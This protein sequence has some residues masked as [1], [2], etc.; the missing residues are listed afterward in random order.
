MYGR[1]KQPVSSMS[2]RFQLSVCRL[3][4]T[5][6]WYRLALGLISWT[7]QHVA[8]RWQR[9]AFW[10]LLCLA[11][12]DHRLYVVV[13]ATVIDPRYPGWMC[14]VWMYA[15][16]SGCWRN[17]PPLQQTQLERIARPRSRRDHQ[18]NVSATE[19]VDDAQPDSSSVLDAC[20][21]QFLTSA[22]KR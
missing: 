4:F 22:N 1:W 13:V 5:R 18:R 7:T 9:D 8:C 21:N 12:T 20:L 3:Q 16:N 17:A 10:C 14:G 19:R 11:V 2:V 6:R 15:S